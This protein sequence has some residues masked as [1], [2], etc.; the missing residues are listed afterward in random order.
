MPPAGQADPNAALEQALERGPGT[1]PWSG[2]LERRHPP[3]RQAFPSGHKVRP[4]RPASRSLVPEGR[5]YFGPVRPVLP[6]RDVRR[7]VRV[8]CASVT[9]A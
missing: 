2:A 3:V 7:D 4:A 6:D 1:G 9:G 5:E 8:T